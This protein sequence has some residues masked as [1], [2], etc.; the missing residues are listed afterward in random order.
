VT[1]EKINKRREPLSKLHEQR[2]EQDLILWCWS[3]KSNEVVFEDGAVKLIYEHS[4]QFEKLYD[5][6]IPLIQVENVRY[7][8]AKLAIAFAARFYSNAENGK[9]L[10]V[11]KL[12]VDCVTTFFHMI[13]AKESC[14]YRA[15]S[16]MKKSE[17]ENVTDEKIAFIEH[18][19]KSWTNKE[20]LLRFVMVN[21]VFDSRGIMEHM[22]VSQFQSSEVI[23][24]L[25]HACCISKR[26]AFYTKTPAFISYLKAALKLRSNKVNNK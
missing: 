5:F 23:S 25:S 2:L 19:F 21:N 8:V 1:G 26:G 11:K 3:R 9:I 14:G 24:K 22:G 15:Y 18:Y 17:S 13:Y 6:S 16:D 7:K 20:E 4:L 12:H 10:L